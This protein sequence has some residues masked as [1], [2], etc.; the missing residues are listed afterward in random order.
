MPYLIIAL[1]FALPFLLFLKNQGAFFGFTFT[2]LVRALNFSALVYLVLCL[3][4]AFLFAW[5]DSNYDVDAA[6]TKENIAAEAS[7]GFIMLSLGVILPLL[8]ILNIV[9]LFV[10]KKA[11]PTE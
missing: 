6:G 3:G 1:L 9:K 5:L 2:K 4:F 11:K 8:I 10:K 7:M